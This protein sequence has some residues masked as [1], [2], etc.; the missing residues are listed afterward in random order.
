LGEDKFCETKNEKP[1]SV[2]L[3]NELIARR[4]TQTHIS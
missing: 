3:E 1:I 2:S 4:E